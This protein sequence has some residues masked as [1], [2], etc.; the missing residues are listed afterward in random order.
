MAGIK[1]KLNPNFERDLMK[2]A[3]GAMNDTATKYQRMFDSLSRE[4]TGQPVS[5]IKPVLRG[6]WRR[7]GGNISDP[8]LT[9]YATHISDGTRI[10]MK[11]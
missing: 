9:E 1:V 7:L 8:E 10:V 3:Q 5:V 2:L 6:H 11:T 4:Y